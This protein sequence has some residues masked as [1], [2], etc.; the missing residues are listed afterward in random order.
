MK[1]PTQTRSILKTV[2]TV[3]ASVMGLLV[4]LVI[5]GLIAFAQSGI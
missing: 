5:L 3:T 4:V 1:T 2:V